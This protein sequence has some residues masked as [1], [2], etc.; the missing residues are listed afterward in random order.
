M[1]RRSKEQPPESVSFENIEVYRDPNAVNLYASTARVL[2]SPFEFL[3]ALGQIEPG[4]G[5]KLNPRLKEIGTLY[6][7]PTHAKA[8][9]M[10]LMRK[11]AE[12]EIEYGR[13]PMPPEVFEEEGSG[14]NA[15][16]EPEQPSSRS[17]G[18]ARAKASRP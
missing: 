17:R 11:V 16:S 4:I 8:L 14:L 15:S 6:L 7:T 18:A 3:I 2:S 9:T 1:V 13:I 12:Y 10:I 5:P